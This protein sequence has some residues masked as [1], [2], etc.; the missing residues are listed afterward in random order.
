MEE[1]TS[2][3]NPRIRRIIQLQS[4]AR[5][6]KEEGSFITEGVRIFKDTPDEAL[7]A[8][9]VTKERLPEL[10]DLILGKTRSAGAPVCVIP[11]ALME[12]ISDTKTPQ[13]ILCEVRMPSCT[14]EDLLREEAPLLLM[15]EAIQDP[16]NLGTMVRTAEAAGA[17]GIILS[18]ECADL[19]SAK[20]VRATMSAIFRMP[21]LTDADLREEIRA[22]Q[23][24]RVRIYA[25]CLDDRACPYDRF[26]YT[27]GTGYGSAFLVGNEG[28]GLQ[29]ET[30]R[31]S[32]E[33]VYLPMAG[34]IESLNAAVAASILL[35]EA[36]R[37]RRNSGR[38]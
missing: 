17:A 3:Q 12:K 10:Q 11:Q 32:D 13:G 33:T 15:L 22:L 18:R 8:V 16:G 20:T 28:N 21:I 26:D 4:K 19:Y 27:K 37:Q 25:A 7:R 30:I 36:A 31:L 5:V 38:E 23:E 34:Q 1:I 2:P 35:Y 14:R 6:R 29:E 24:N 9:Y